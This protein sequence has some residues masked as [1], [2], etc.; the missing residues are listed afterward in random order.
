MQP[1]PLRVC[2]VGAGPAGLYAADALTFQSDVPVTVD[3]I[4]LLPTPFGL[5]RYGVAPDHLNIK[6]AARALH[7]VLERPGVNLFAN[8][9]VGTDVTIAELRT[10][11]DVVIYA[12]G[13]SADRQLGIPG[14]AL[15]GCESATDFVS[16]YNGHPDRVNREVVNSKQVAIVGA[17]N[18]ALDVARVLLKEPAELERTDVPEDVLETLRHSTVTDVHLIARRAPHFAKFTA[19]ELRE[20]GQLA[21]VDVIFDGEQL[22]G[23]PDAGLTPNETRNI[24][25]LTEWAQ[26]VP[27]GRPRRLHLHFQALPVEVV[28]ETH[29]AALRLERADVNGIGTGT[30]F[31]LNVQLVLRSVG[32]RALPIPGLPFDPMKNTIPTLDHRVQRNGTTSA[33]EYAVGWIKRGPTGILGT[34]RKDAAETVATVLLDAPTLLA[35]RERSPAGI[36]PILADRCVQHVNLQRWLAIADA[37]ATHGIAGRT[38]PVKLGDWSAL[39][40]AATV[41]QRASKAE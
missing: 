19:K 2:V 14:E 16:W 13:A 33:G 23:S 17:G 7:E 37:E 40:K 18:V 25:V 29:V 34:N 28:G 24:A 10:N 3:L 8:V 39:L 30:T 22:E 9:A 31:D 21:N 41:S 4:E 15:A 27:T 1:R 12:L 35:K 38:G 11:Y 36:D 20:L 5:L 6:A 26:R 32:Y